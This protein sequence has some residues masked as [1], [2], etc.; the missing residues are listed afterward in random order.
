MALT[1]SY[2]HCI[3]FGLGAIAF[4][5]LS[6]LMPWPLALHWGGGGRGLK[7]VSKYQ[8]LFGPALMAVMNLGFVSLV[9]AM[10]SSSATPWAVGAT[11]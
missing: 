4:L 2:W 11:E 6:K 5:G 3:G 1:L 8:L 9:P 7:R 10:L